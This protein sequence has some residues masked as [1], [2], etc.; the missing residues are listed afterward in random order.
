MIPERYES[1]TLSGWQPAEG[2]RDPRRDLQ[3]WVTDPKRPWCITFLGPTGTGKTHLATATFALWTAPGSNRYG[4]WLDSADAINLLRE[5]SAPG[6]RPPERRTLV[7][8]K[9]S[10][11][12]LLLLDDFGCT[13]LTDFAHEQFMFAFSRRYNSFMPTIITTNAEAL[14]A[15]DAVDPRL[16]SRLHEGLVVKL[17]GRD[18]RVA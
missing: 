18:R 17:S 16:T 11:P 7:A 14:E 5:E 4:W 2:E 10:D 6:V 13:R 9:L 15:F 1:M 12:R 3:R 8:T